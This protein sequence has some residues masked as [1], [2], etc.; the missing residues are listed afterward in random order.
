MFMS[1]IVRSS[2]CENLFYIYDMVRLNW[3]PAQ[4][5]DP[6]ARYEIPLKISDSIGGG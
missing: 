3:A 1:G 5:F 2:S 6:K 4:E